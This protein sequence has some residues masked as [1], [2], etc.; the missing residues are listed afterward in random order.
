MN[1]YPWRLTGSRGPDIRVVEDANGIPLSVRCH[2]LPRPP[3]LVQK[4]HIDR[5]LDYGVTKVELGALMTRSSGIN[6]RAVRLRTRG[7]N[8]SSAMPA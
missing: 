4:E 3:G 8:T 6:R 2:H 7:S 5:M 1:T